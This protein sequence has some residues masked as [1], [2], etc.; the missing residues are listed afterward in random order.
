[1]YM[2]MNY[3]NEKTTEA[4][5]YLKNGKKK[6]GWLVDETPFAENFHFISHSNIPGFNESYSNDYVEVIP[7]CQIEAIETD[8][9]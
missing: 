7:G 8:L 1:M 6:F 3:S 2:I 9:R 5:I 4:I